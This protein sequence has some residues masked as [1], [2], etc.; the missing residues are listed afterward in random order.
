MFLFWLDLVPHPLIVR[1]N[2]DGTDRIVIVDTRL[3]LPNRLTLDFEL[4]FV[5]WCDARIDVVE[6]VYFDGRF[7]Y[8]V[9]E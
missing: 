3:E 8:E 7:V 6:Y 9:Y 1:V 2:L 5:Y 4:E